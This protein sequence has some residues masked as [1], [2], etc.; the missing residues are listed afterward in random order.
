M[1]STEAE[2]PSNGIGVLGG[3][4]NVNAAARTRLKL[5]DLVTVLE[6]R[7]E[8]P[9]RTSP[10][11]QIREGWTCRGRL[12]TSKQLERRQTI[13]GTWE[14]IPNVDGMLESEGPM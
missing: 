6:S 11:A 13:A 1:S 10:H 12:N 9:C 8:D 3:I 2:N 14:I 4:S 7:V 5:G